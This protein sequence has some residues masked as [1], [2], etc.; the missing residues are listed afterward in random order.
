MLHARM[1]ELRRFA[2]WSLPLAVLVC[3]RPA[4]PDS[5]PRA[6]TDADKGAAVQLK[7]GET[8]EVRLK[9]NPT[10]GYAWSLAPESTPLVRLTAR[11]RTEPVGPGVGR[12]IMQIFDF[13]AARR[14]QGVLFLHYVRSWEKPAQGEQRFDLHLTIH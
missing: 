3:A 11:S 13:Q 6:F 9:S 12:P 4:L 2:L 5:A 8:F 1:R 10:T 7:V 14:G